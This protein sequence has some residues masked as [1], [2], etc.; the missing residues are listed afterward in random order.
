MISYRESQLL[1]LINK[2]TEINSIGT[3]IWRN[4]EGQIH[5]GNDK[6]AVEYPDGNKS[7]FING[8]FI[9]RNY[10][11]NGIIHNDKFFDYNGN[12]IKTTIAQL[13][14]I[15]ENLNKPTEILSD[16][17][18]IWKNKEDE[19]HRLNDKPAVEYPDGEKEWYINDERHRDNDKPA[20]ERP[21][22]KKEWYINGKF[23]K[24]NYDK[25]NIIHNNKLFDYE[26][27]EI[28]TT[29]AQLSKFLGYQAGDVYEDDK[30]YYFIGAK[31]LKTIQIKVIGKNNPYVFDNNYSIDQLKTRKLNK[32]NKFPH[33]FNLNDDIVYLIDYSKCKIFGVEFNASFGNWDY[34]ITND[35]GETKKVSEINLSKEE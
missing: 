5:R 33:K 6:P 32:T 4:K 19:L 34:F 23:I 18:K 7:W 16:G 14:K 24:R 20:V 28:M 25:N 22:G 3:K 29:T 31:N 12:E 8:V 11:R 30:F 15:I 35:D 2:P 17:T 9:K 10:D 1:D 21:N 13:R 26:G 27:Y